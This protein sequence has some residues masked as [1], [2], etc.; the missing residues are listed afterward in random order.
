MPPPGYEYRCVDRSVLKPVYDFL[1]VRGVVR[2]LSPRRAANDVSLLSQLFA[3][4]PV[5]VTVLG[6]ERGTWWLW[7]VLAPVGYLGYIVFDNADGAHARKTSTSSPLGELVD[8][9][10]D[11]WNAALL[12]TAWGLAWGA[13][14]VV[15]CAL[16]GV[17]ALAYVASIDE[18]RATG[19]LKL[20][21]VGACEAMTAMMLSMVALGVFGRDACLAARLPFGLGVSDA[22]QWVCG[23]GSGGAALAAELRQRGR[24]LAGVAHFVVGGALVL[25]WVWLGLHPLVGAFA[26]AGLSAISAGRSVLARTTGISPRA[27][28]TSLLAL[29]AGVGATAAGV[30]RADWIGL[31]VVVVV[32]ARATADF[33]WGMRALGRWLRR[34]EVLGRIAWRLVPARANRDR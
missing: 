13:R 30:A 29:G 15:A 6:G 14:P 33:S 34:E 9:W 4:L 26:L 18:H 12:P 31:A 17:T 16:G 19:Q 5:A 27:D 2:G 28:A 7:G 1:F 21:A 25:A 22:L 20:D 23:V 3:L 8:H 32:I 24:G 11:A 10:Y